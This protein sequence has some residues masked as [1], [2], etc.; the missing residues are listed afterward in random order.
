MPVGSPATVLARQQLLSGI[1]APATNAET[2]IATTP[3]LTTG[4]PPVV[5]GVPVPAPVR[6]SGIFNVTPGTAT[7]A[8]TIRCR[9]GTTTGGPQVGNS[10][11]TQPVTVGDPLTIPFSFEDA[12]GYLQQEFAGGGVFYVITAQQ[13]SATGNGTSNTFEMEVSE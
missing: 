13:T 12:S 3:A 4:A 8:I 10:L 5:G 9:Q 11:V 2:V 6:L 7:T 1:P